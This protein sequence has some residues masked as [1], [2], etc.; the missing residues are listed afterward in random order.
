MPYITKHEILYKDDLGETARIDP[1]TEL[2]KAE[3]KALGKEN[4]DSLVKSKAITKVTV[5]EAAKVNDG[6]GPADTK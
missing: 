3:E 4:L 5:A 1:N 6:F 2:T